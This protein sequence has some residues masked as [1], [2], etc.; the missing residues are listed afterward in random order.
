LTVRWTKLGLVY[1]ASGEQPWAQ[2]HAYVPTPVVL[3]ETTIRVYA[4]FLDREKVGRV[5]YVDV[6]ARNPTRVLGVSQ[7]PAFD[8]GLP[9]TFDDSGVTPVS[10]VQRN[11]RSHLYYMGWQLGRGVRYY[12][13]TGLA[14][15]DDGRPFRRWSR[16]PVLERSDGELFVRSGACV[17]AEGAAWTMWYVAGDRWVDVDGKATPTYNLRRLTSCDGVT[18][19]SAGQ[20]CLELQAPDEYGFG[21]PFVCKGPAGYRMWY[22][23]RTFSK[24]YRLGYAESPDGLAWR[25]KDDEV[26]IDVSAS[27]WDSEMICFAA[28]VRA[29]GHSYLF[30]NG[31][32]YGQTGF[33]VAV[34]EDP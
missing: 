33:G 6:D 18:W 10:V 28:V 14:I 25:R 5:G 21:R 16:T 19:G 23:I 15:S 30:Y 2:S 22:S 12:L 7:S 31:N 9:G 27:G 17:L 34:G 29:G 20:V 1:V 8:V 26:G 13:L 4:A 3:D 24:G 11:G 32:N